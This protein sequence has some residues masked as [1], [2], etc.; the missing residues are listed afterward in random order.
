MN[1]EQ[2]TDLKITVKGPKTAL[3]ILMIRTEKKTQIPMTNPEMMT[4]TRILR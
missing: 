2:G 1:P 4:Y 3:R